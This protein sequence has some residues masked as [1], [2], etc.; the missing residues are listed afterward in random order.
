MD[1]QSMY[2]SDMYIV[3]GIKANKIIFF[4]DDRTGGIAA[5]VVEF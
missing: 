1:A 2:K 3:I 5:C 4:F